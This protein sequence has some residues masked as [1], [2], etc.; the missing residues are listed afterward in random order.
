MCHVFTKSGWAL[1]P[2]NKSHMCFR[3]FLETSVDIIISI[4]C[5][6]NLACLVSHYDNKNLL[7]PLFLI[8]L[9][10]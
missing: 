10:L 9:S 3:M 4:E 8:T 6:F 7:S 2:L 1:L 5:P